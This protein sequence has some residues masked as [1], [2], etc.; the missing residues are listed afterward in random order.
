MNIVWLFFQ[1]YFMINLL[2]TSNT[3]ILNWTDNFCHDKT[4]RF[5]F[6]IRNY[7]WVTQFSSRHFYWHDKI[8][9]KAINC[10]SQSH[11]VLIDRKN[12][13]AFAHI[14]FSLSHLNVSEINWG[15]EL[16]RLKASLSQYKNSFR[17]HNSYPLSDLIFSCF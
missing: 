14:K 2:F 5:L 15:E 8:S 12:E 10:E 3:Q 9:Q 1:I 7:F 16:N 4:K 17:D 6:L 11:I 13:I